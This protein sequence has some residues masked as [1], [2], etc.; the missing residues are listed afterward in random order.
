[1]WTGVAVGAGLGVALGLGML[2]G[3]ELLVADGSGLAT[4]AGEAVARAG[5]TL[6]VAGAQAARQKVMRIKSALQGFMASIMS[7]KRF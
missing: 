7:A 5:T 6:A 2:V 1:M 3:W 4:G